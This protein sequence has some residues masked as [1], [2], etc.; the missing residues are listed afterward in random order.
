MNA[1]AIDLRERVIR[2][3]DDDATATQPEV[4][5]H[6]QISLSTVEKW[7]RRWREQQT[8]APLPD[9]SGAAR[10]LE[11]YAHVLRQTLAHQPAATLQELCDAVYTVAG[12][13]TSPS[14][15]CRELQILKLPRKKV[16]V[17]QS[18]RN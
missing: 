11:P 6:F 14:M 16:L 18:T 5:E 8:V 12:V 2:M 7:W 4:A 13:R 17:R 10:A 15:M 1:Y 3:L 9:A